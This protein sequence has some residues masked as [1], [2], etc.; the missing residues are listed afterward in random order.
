[1]RDAGEHATPAGSGPSVSATAAASMSSSATVPSAAA[2]ASRNSHGWNSRPVIAATCASNSCRSR[3]AVRSHTCNFC[4]SQHVRKALMRFSSRC[5]AHPH[6]PVG[7]RRRQEPPVRR[8]AHVTDTGA[9]A[10]VC[11]QARAV[12]QVVQP[13]T[14]VRRTRGGKLVEGVDTERKAGARAAFAN[15]LHCCAAQAPR[16]TASPGSTSKIYEVRPGL[17]ATAPQPMQRSKS[18]IVPSVAPAAA[19]VSSASSAR[20]HTSLV[21]PRKHCMDTRRINR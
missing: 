17:Q 7:R 21:C 14:A 8:K 1:M 5:A 11:M 4:L 15:G 19:S 10:L 3:P 20:L 12:A 6:T 2:A 16:S 18:L 13:E 9:V